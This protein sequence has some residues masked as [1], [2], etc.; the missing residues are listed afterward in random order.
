M[1]G[2]T[3]KFTSAME[4]T[5]VALLTELMAPPILVFPDWDVVSNKCRPFRWMEF[6]S[7]YNFSL[8]YH[9]GKDNNTT[10]A[11][12]SQTDSPSLPLKRAFHAL[13]PRQTRS[14][15]ASTSSKSVVLYPVPVLSLGFAWVGW[16]PFRLPPQVLAWVG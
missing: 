9:C 4:D 10:L 8:S 12:N 16:P 13:A 14:T 6:L 15:L 1:I 11:L 7:V 2:A 5:F 3:I